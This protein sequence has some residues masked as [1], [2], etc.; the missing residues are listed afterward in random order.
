MTT[1]WQQQLKNPIS[2]LLAE[3]GSYLLQENGD[4]II[5]EQ[6]GLATSLWNL[7]NKN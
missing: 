7:Q 4:K 5:L 1:L 2:Y 3:D 6:T